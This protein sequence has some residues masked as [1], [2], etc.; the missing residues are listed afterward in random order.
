[1]HRRSFRTIGFASSRLGLLFAFVSVCGPAATAGAADKKVLPVTVTA[2]VMSNWCWAASSEMTMVHE[3]RNGCSDVKQCTHV[4]KKL[5][6]SA[7]CCN[8]PSECDVPGWPLFSEFKF[9]SDKTD[10]AAVGWD[11]L[12]AEIDANRPICGTVKWVDSPAG[13]ALGH[14][15]L[16]RGYELDNQGKK[17]VHVVDPSPLPDP[18]AEISALRRGGEEFRM[19]Y[20]DY[21]GCSTAGK[22]NE[23][24][25]AFTHWNDYFNIKPQ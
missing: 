24:W 6:S 12:K 15:F 5:G 23:R 2:Q 22:V 19:T 10:H 3:G 13:G 14:M 1:M 17:W 11:A 9:T 7:T 4:A 20:E 16:V 21:Q 25:G 8:A 18:D